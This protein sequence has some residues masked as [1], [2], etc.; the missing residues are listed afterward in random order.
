LIATTYNSGTV[1]YAY[2]AVGNNTIMTDTVGI[3][4]EPSEHRIKD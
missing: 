4:C 1:S 3:T 2:D